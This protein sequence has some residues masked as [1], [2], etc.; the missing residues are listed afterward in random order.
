MG[1]DELSRYEG[2]G[3]NI[4]LSLRFL[5]DLGYRLGVVGPLRSGWFW[6]ER[7]SLVVVVVVILLLPLLSTFI[8]YFGR[9]AG[10]QR[11]RET[12]V[13][14]SPESLKPHN[15]ARAQNQVETNIDR[16]G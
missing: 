10:H 3:I 4:N 1:R 12:L 16:K 6:D 15:M 7:C 2:S 8:S 5:E 14:L 13:L 11:R 9:E